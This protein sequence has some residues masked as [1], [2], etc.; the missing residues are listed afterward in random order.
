MRITSQGRIIAEIQ[1]FTQ[2]YIFNCKAIYDQRLINHELQMTAQFFMRI[3]RPLRTEQIE[4]VVNNSFR[5]VADASDS[6]KEAKNI[7]LSQ[8]YRG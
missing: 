6:A 7:A 8:R 3:R 1:D 5:D 2:K 4:A